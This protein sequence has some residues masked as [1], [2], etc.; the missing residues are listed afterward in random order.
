MKI[1]FALLLI[2]SIGLITCN[3]K[4]QEETLDP[5]TGSL[6]EILNEELEPLSLEPLQW[7]NDELKFLDGVSGRSVVAFGEA[8]HGTSEFF[9]AKDKMFRY[10]AENHGFKI[11]A[12]EA[13]FGESLLINE[14]V[15]NSDKAQIENLMKTKMHFWTWRT[16][17][18]RNLLHW[19]CD[20]NVG[21]PESEKVQYWG[22]DC[23]F[24]TYHPDM[25]REYL[26]SA[27]VSFISFADSLLEEAK[28]ATAA[29]FSDYTNSTFGAY[30]EKMDALKDSI[31]SYEEQIIDA[32]NEREYKLIL[33]LVDVIRQV[34]EVRF[35]VAKQTATKN[36]RDEY[37]AKNT[38]W[39]HEYFNGAKIVVWAHNF[40]VSDYRDA[41]SMGH[42]LKTDFADDYVIFGFL[43]AKGSFTA[44]T[45][46]GGQFYGLDTHT[47][48]EE[49]MESTLPYLMSLAKTPSFTVKISDLQDYSEW[50]Q[51]F[52]NGIRF[53][54]M[55]AVYN[56]NPADY[57]EP[58][59]ATYF[60][61]LI[62]FNT[63]K[64]AAQL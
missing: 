42:Y 5:I 37:M 34:S 14:A 61:H 4:E 7:T 27:N 39:L 57:Y 55:G 53:F 52:V 32:I 48:D 10:L 49:P 31:T 16:T 62:F 13:D 43:F 64:A 33:Q 12:I 59:N 22:F 63:T 20:Y 28:S 38:A 25:V 44:I 24:N 47:I 2:L 21:K 30:L 3:D 46:S 45:Q 54:Q 36:Y 58:F 40:H 50:R 60:D 51:K 56:N 17:D 18:V 11:F 26:T 6:V 15:L 29:E 35:Y 41:G 1:Q 8:T 19:M 23:Q 9:K